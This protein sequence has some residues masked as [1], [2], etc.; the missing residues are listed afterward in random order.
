MPI[1]YE[2]VRSIH[3][4]AGTGQTVDVGSGS[5]V[6]VIAGS[7]IVNVG[8]LDRRLDNF[9]GLVTVVGRDGSSGPVVNLDNRLGTGMLYT[10]GPEGVQFRGLG[11][12]A[13]GRVMFN[14][15]AK[16]VLQGG[17]SADLFKMEGTPAAAVRVEAGGGADRLDYTA[18]P[19][20]VVV[21]LGAG[22]ATGLDAGVVGVEHV[23]GSAGDDHLVGDDAANSLHG[24]EGD[25]R[26]E[27][28]GG[29]D[30]LSG[31]L[32]DDWLSGGD[33]R[34]SLYATAALVSG[35]GSDTL[36]GGPGA[37]RLFAGDG[38][39]DDHLD[40]AE[41]ALWD[42]EFDPDDTLTGGP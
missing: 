32:G 15:V 18:Y 36:I 7:G 34:D 26:L 1:L 6:T 37:D 9:A 8:G 41:D 23:T 21:N 20:G 42:L 33:G 17:A 12:S 40:V 5:T 28:L 27:G 30:V 2:A 4:W 25:D 39:G 29:D 35:A 16:V 14:G 11:T 22:V 3:F 13:D 10:V 24:G 38:I 19:T 31:G